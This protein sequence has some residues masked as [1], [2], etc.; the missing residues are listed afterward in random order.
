MVELR[1]EQSEELQKLKEV[2][3]DLENKIQMRNNTVKKLQT[4]LQQLFSQP[5]E[6]LIDNLG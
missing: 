2:N 5:Q 1:H 4:T 3:I 6:E